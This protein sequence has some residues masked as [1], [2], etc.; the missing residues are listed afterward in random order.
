MVIESI[1][2]KNYRNYESLHL[3][4]DPGTNILC[5][6]NAQGKT[7]ILES[8]CLGCTA[9]SHKNARDRD[10]IRFGEEEAHIKMQVKKNGVPYR[11]DM[12]LKKNKPKGIAIGGVP[13]R[14]AS[15]LFGIA[16]VVSF[17]PEDLNLVKN[18]PAERRR[19]IDME[20][21]QLDKLYVHA[22]SHYNRVLI[23]RNKL[24]KELNFHPDYEATLD[25]WD[26]QLV[27][28]GRQVIESRA[29][30]IARLNEMIGGIHSRLSGGREMLS[31]AY[32]PDRTA[33]TFESAV[34]ASRAQDIRQKT[35]LCGPHRD[36]MSFVVGGVD[37][38]RF[39]SQ[40]QQR[41]AALS[42][43]LSELELVK[44]LIHDNPILLLDDVL[45]EL[46]SGRQNHLLST[47]GGIQ[48][49]ITCTGLDDFV[50]NRFQI[51]Q[52]FKVTGGTAVCVNQERKM[53]K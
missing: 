43:K 34:A 13:I 28:Y 32:E 14:R 36:D 50:N 2:L 27:N 20:L 26:L 16:N 19:F 46:D 1:E 41:T 6:D 51:D 33:Q 49:V 39:G 8:I 22:L 4:L 40:G 21:C 18:G 42:L 35:T 30:F 25:V 3:T 38:R 5:G 24:L 37:I 9:R 47:I 29:K 48:T 53:K 31:I 7:N 15:E 10:I 17:S 44:E 12:H 23:Q 45:S 52:V 11:V